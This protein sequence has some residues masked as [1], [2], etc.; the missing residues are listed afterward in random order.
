MAW[1]E[2]DLTRGLAALRAA[3]LAALAGPPQPALAHTGFVRP[4][5][6]A[7]RRGP[8][9]GAGL[10]LSEATADA[11]MLA[12]GYGDADLAASSE[13]DE[14]ERERL[15][16]LVELARGGDKEAFGLLFDHYHG[17]V[18]RFLFYRTRSQTLAEDLASE[19]FF[20]ALR[21]MN[22]FR[23]QGKDF[24]AWLMTIARN[25]AT[26]HFKAGRTRLE[27]A[28]DD[29]AVHDAPAEGPE[30]MVLD[31]LTNEALLTALKE[32][33]KEQQECLIMRFLQ[34]LSIAETAQVLGR[35]DGAVKQL[36]LRGVRNLA[37]LLPEGLRDR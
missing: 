11:G 31:A 23:W 27:L 22:S 32:L 15:I 18:Y 28:T 7:V 8:R 9:L 6:S 29:M 17:S 3:V 33:P 24:G 37:K 19:T 34:G 5:T 25:L 26:D 36:Q 2:R 35:S 14:A 13:D 12:G 10:L 30:S 1:G 21:S 16:A 4:D 20:R